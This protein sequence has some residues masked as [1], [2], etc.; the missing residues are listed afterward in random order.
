M[1]RGYP[2]FEGPK[3]GIYLKPEWAAKEAIDKSLIAVNPVAAFGDY[4]TLSYTVPVGKTLYITKCSFYLCADAAADGD[5]D[6]VCV[7]QVYDLTTNSYLWQQGGNGGGGIGLP[8]PAVAPAGHT[9]QIRCTSFANHTSE[10]GIY[11][12][13]YEL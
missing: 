1:A 2:D 5:K 8:K 4:A 11:V 3:S 7:G 12:G 10:A 9:L 6:Q 13:G